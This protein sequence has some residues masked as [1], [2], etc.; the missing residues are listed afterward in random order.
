MGTGRDS[1]GR[2]RERLADKEFES[3]VSKPDQGGISDRREVGRDRGVEVAHPDRSQR[4]DDGSEKADPLFSRGGR[5]HGLGEAVDQEAGIRD[6][7][8]R[9][10]R[11]H[12]EGGRDS[13]EREI[14]DRSG[15]TRRQNAQSQNAAEAHRLRR[16]KAGR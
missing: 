4:M 8:E 1:A 7:G 9:S 6:A 11:S 16:E 12:A 14:V 2:G 13:T 10:Q 5:D 3:S 15:G